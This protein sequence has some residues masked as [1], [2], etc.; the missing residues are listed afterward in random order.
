MGLDDVGEL[1]AFFN[2]CEIAD[3]GSPDYEV[4]EV[5]DEWADLDLDADLMVL[6][7]NDGRIVGTM[8]VTSDGPAV[9]NASGY[10]HP[11]AK[12]RGVGTR[13]VAWS[14]ERARTSGDRGSVDRSVL[15]NWVVATN[16][17]AAGILRSRGYHRIKQFAR[18]EIELEK[19]PEAAGLP[20]GY[21]FR[22]FDEERD[23]PGIYAVVE[24][25]FAEHW[26]ATPR[27]YETWSKTALGSGYE[28]KLWAQVFHGDQRV[29]VAI[30]Q[31]LAGYGWIKW[32]GVMKEYR[33]NGIGLAMLRNQFE[34][35]WGMGIRSIG[36]GVDTDNTTG[37]KALYERAGMNQSRSHDAWEITLEPA[38]E[39]DP[40]CQDE[41]VI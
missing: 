29:G 3:F 33:G 22:P 19:G 31:N 32:V 21:S 35:Y 26:T 25:S 38:S 30:G 40:M 1:T 4:E 28:P 10:V 24:D 16:E 13:L 20:T 39:S 27:T 2:V 37:A 5:R 6:E 11:E 7:G 18:M 41:L 36:L 12:G 23:L 15:I 14:E 8:T 17:G 9:F 34:R